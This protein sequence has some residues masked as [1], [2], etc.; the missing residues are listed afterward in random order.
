MQ[1]NMKDIDLGSGRMIRLHN[2]FICD[3]N[4]SDDLVK[5]T[6]QSLVDEGAQV[7]VASESYGVDDM[8]NENGI[9]AIAKSMGLEATGGQRDYQA[10]R[11]YKTHPHGGHQR[12]HPSQNA[13]NRQF[14]GRRAYA[15]PA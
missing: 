6:I 12:L 3:E 9:C 13:G 5:R 14:H 2:R 8:E 11:T 4:L 7:I 10:L 1:T 15:A